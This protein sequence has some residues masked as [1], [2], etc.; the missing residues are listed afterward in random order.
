MGVR[1]KDRLGAGPTLVVGAVVV[2]IFALDAL[3]APLVAPHDPL[4]GELARRLLPPVWMGGSADYLLGTDG[5]GRDVLSRLVWGARVSF[6]LGLAG[7]AIAAGVGTALGMVAGWWEGWLD[8]LLGRLADFLLAFPML[9]F[10]IGV[11]TALGSG[12][13]NLILA[14]SLKSWVEFMRLVRGQV[15]AHK[16]LVYVDAA[17]ALGRSGAGILAWEILPNIFHGVLVLATLRVGYLIIA[18]ASLSFLGLGV[19]PPTPEWGAMVND[20]RN[21]ML[22]AWWLSTFPGLAIVVLVLGLNLLS[23]GL[24]ELLDPRFRDPGIPR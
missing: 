19:Q 15:L 2:A 14:L 3:L 11:I 18:A 21:F 12:F 17:H 4:H 8:G 5:L 10:A 13:W 1:L 22:S 20:G 6:G 23:E 9:I 7:A 24:H 16:Q